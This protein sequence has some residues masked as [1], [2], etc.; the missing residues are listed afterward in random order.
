MNFYDE[1]FKKTN[2]EATEYKLKYL[3]SVVN[4]NTIY[5]FIQFDENYSLNNVK[6]NA[7]KDEV[8]WFSYYKYLN[9]KTEFEINYDI[10]QVSRETNKSPEFIKYLFDIIVEV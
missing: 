10:I 4:N 7:L 2:G 3:K 8:L 9:D 6:L 5:K 1:Y